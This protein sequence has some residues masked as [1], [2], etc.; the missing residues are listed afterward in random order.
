[1]GKILPSYDI[2]IMEVHRVF[3]VKA[4]EYGKSWEMP[5]IIVIVEQIYTKIRKIKTIT[6]LSEKIN[7]VRND[8]KNELMSIINYSALGYHRTSINL[9]HIKPEELV[10]IYEKILKQAQDDIFN[11]PKNKEDVMDKM[12]IETLIYLILQHITSMKDS[13]NTKGCVSVGDLKQNFLDII[14]YAIFALMILN[15]EESK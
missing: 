5:R 12:D 2:V 1:M 7:L 4:S 3:K 14:N 9:P 8:T 10:V 15:R 11:S 6:E 13:L